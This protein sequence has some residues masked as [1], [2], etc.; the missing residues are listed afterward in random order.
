MTN[1]H[2]WWGVGMACVGMFVAL[3]LDDG[4]AG[5]MFAGAALIFLWRI[6]GG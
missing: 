2:R 3:M 5:F 6:Y 4:P 1:T